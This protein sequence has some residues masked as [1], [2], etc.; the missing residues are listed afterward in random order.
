MGLIDSI[1][2]SA[3]DSGQ[4]VGALT[5]LAYS[6]GAH[7]FNFW[8]YEPKTGMIDS[9]SGGLDPEYV[10]PYSEHYYQNDVWL[11]P[12][13]ERYSAGDVM[14]GPE[15]IGESAFLASEFYNDFLRPQDI[16]HAFGL[17]I[18]N[19]AGCST[20]MAAFRG[21][22]QEEYSDTERQFVQHLMPHLR[23]AARVR[24][25]LAG[26]EYVVNALVEALDGLS[27]GV[28]LLDERGGILFANAQAQRILNNC[29]GLRCR[30]REL[31]VSDREAS[32]RV[33]LAIRDAIATAQGRP[34]MGAQ[35]LAIPRPSGKRP[36]FTT[37]VPVGP[38][39]ASACRIRPGETPAAMV[40]LDDPHER[41]GEF[42]SGLQSLFGLTEAEAEVAEG[43]ACGWSAAEIAEMRSVALQTVRRQIKEILGKTGTGRQAEL[44]ALIS[45]VRRP[46]NDSVG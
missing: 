41:S 30:T 6:I 4:W 8:V 40:F 2:D 33:S 24:R 45:R 5:S 16:R 10:A 23:R 18:E 20:Y 34:Q 14:T 12:F 42:A 26:L 29:D 11:P 15:L 38:S 9:A 28:V 22:G 35:T 46:P 43:L 36:Y 27:A 17:M 37:V 13:F 21:H 7:G 44:V 31:V 32:R 39:T 3:L 1:N 25:K 19:S